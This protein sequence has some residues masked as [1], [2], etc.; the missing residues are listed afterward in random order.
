MPTEASQGPG[1][2]VIAE[3]NAIRL[4][5]ALAIARETGVALGKSTLQRW[6]KVWAET[7]GSPVK[8][9]LQVTRNGRHYEIDRD[10]FEAWLLE[11]VQNQETPR[12]PARP[13]ETSQDPVR[14]H[15]TQQDPERSQEASREAAKDADQLKA[16]QTE[17]MDLKIDL[18]V[19]KQL[20][21]RASQEMNDMR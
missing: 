16:L 20:L 5:E 13:A 2:V 8:V 18:G 3:A 19:R 6:A 17:I 9:V 12:D 10:D 4:A 21:D 11:Q 14:S 1:D 7:A 15:E